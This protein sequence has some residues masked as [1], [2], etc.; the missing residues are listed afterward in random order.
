M[1]VAVYFRR[2]LIALSVS[3]ISKERFTLQCWIIFIAGQ[4]KVSILQNY[5]KV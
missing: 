2:N 4:E 1:L 5:W 3:A